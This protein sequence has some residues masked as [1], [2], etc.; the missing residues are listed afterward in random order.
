MKMKKMLIWGAGSLGE[1]FYGKYKKN[2]SRYFELIGYVDLDKEKQ[3]KLFCDTTV[4]AP[5]QIAGL[6]WDMILICVIKEEQYH[7]IFEYLQ[8][9]GVNKNRIANYFN[10]CGMGLLRD[11]FLEK[12]Q[13]S[14]DPEIQ[15]IVKYVQNHELSIFNME[16]ERSREEYKVYCDAEGE[17]P[18]VQVNGKRLYYPKEFL[19]VKKTPFLKGIFDEQSKNSPH[20]YIPDGFAMKDNSVLVDAGA[21]GGEF[22]LSCIEQCKKIYIFE[23]ETEWC[24]ALSKTFLPFRDKVKIIHSFLGKENNETT[25]TL[26]YFLKEPI[27]FLKMDVEG[28]EPNVLIGARNVLSMSNAFC[29]VCSYHKPGEAEEIRNL[30]GRYGY[31]TEVSKGYMLFGWDDDFYQA[32]DVRRGMVYGR[33]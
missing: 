20:L 28:E 8:S 19:D 25:K 5:E 3:G 14:N 30:L 16:L 15:D 7:E 31:H 2:F 33:K 13:D 22:S 1:Y 18:Y 12:Y 26:D 17:D 27:D 6:N 24:R 10:G 4:Y 9:V 29:A 11:F 32:M 23:C 21:Q